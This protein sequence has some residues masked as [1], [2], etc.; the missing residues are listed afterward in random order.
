MRS[1]FDHDLETLNT[2]LIAMGGLIESAIRQAVGALLHREGTN[3]EEAIIFDREVDR[4]EVEIESLCLRLLLQQQPVARDLRVI[5]AALKMITDME[6]IGDQAGDIAES[7][8]RLPKDLEIQR[9][10]HIRSMAR[11]ATA[12]VKSAIDAFVARDL[13]LARQVTGMD[14]QVDQLF[15]NVRD[16]L[17][18]IVREGGDIEAAIDL[19]MIAKYFERIGD[20]AVNISEWVVY[21][22]T[23]EH[24]SDESR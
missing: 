5:S 11:E 18:R 14:D 10:E 8:L 17:V 1:K 23:G 7:T 24:K 13:D 2:E 15:L 4:K 12:M 19:L 16:D 22:I 3:A 21:S 20:H 9:V 6:R